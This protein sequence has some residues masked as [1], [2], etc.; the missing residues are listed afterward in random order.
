MNKPKYNPVLVDRPAEEIEPMYF[1]HLRVLENH[2]KCF[3]SGQRFYAS[4]IAINLRVLLFD[5]ISSGNR[6]LLFL[7]GKNNIEFIDTEKTLNEG[8]LCRW[9]P[10]A[11]G[12]ALSRIVNLMGTEIEFWLP[13]FPAIIGDNVLRREYN[14]WW[15]FPVLRKDSN[16][17]FSRKRIVRNYA[18][19]DRGGH[20]SDKI[21]SDYFDITRKN[22]I[23]VQLGIHKGGAS[24]LE[25]EWKD[26]DMV[27]LD[28]SESGKKLIQAIVRQIAHE[29]LLTLLPDT[30]QYI[31][32]LPQLPRSSNPLNFV[33]FILDGPKNLKGKV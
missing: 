31:K 15:E 19:Q 16:S 27:P 4:E 11:E 1:Q 20:V 9:I 26:E 13:N 25:S 10:P 22:E 18:N 32:A 30:S 21:E 12:L 29:T 7:A 14:D 6:S 8:D 3:D 24:S 28:C 5:N 23:G 33:Q 17:F 2:C